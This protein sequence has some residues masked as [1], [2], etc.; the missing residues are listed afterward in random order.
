MLRKSATDAAPPIPRPPTDGDLSLGAR[1][2]R[3]L[4]EDDLA[5]L[6]IC[7]LD[8]I[9][10]AGAVLGA[11]NNAV[12]KHKDRKRKV[13]IK[14]GLGRGELHDLAL[15]PQAVESAGT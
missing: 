3:R 15:L 10:N 1:V 14:Q 2:T 6:S 9:H 11:D 8:S 4:F 7:R 12:Q 5:G 13:Q